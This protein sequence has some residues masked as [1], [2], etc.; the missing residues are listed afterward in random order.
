MQ[1]MLGFLREPE[2]RISS[3]GAEST[4]DHRVHLAPRISLLVHNFRSGLTG[5]I[6][7]PV[8]RSPPLFPSFYFAIF[9][10]RIVYESVRSLAV[11]LV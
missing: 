10:V 3:Y 9:A 8:T 1:E 4:E 7:S 2:A 5:I 11:V 6:G